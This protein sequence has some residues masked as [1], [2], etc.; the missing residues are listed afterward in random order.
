[1]AHLF[2]SSGACFSKRRTTFVSSLVEISPVILEKIFIK[3]FIKLNSLFRN[4]LPLKKGMVLLLNNL[5][6][7]HP[8]MVCTKFGLNWSNSSG[9]EEEDM[10]SL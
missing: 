10:K 3:D 2:Y 8:R 7:F 6:P 9:G 5:N 4:Y 1:M